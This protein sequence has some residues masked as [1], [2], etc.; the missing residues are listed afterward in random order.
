MNSSVNMFLASN[1]S[2]IV[3]WQ[4]YS[5]KIKH[6]FL[7]LIIIAKLLKTQW[8]INLNNNSD[9]I[10]ISI[11]II[12]FITSDRTIKENGRKEKGKRL[13]RWGG[14]LCFWFR[15]VKNWRWR[16]IAMIFSKFSFQKIFPQLGP[17]PYAAP[18]G[19]WGWVV[20]VAR[21]IKSN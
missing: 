10:S 16:K 15:W 9:L 18:D 21:W 13:R 2:P 17:D 5:M 7:L 4:E 8:T 6:S 19:G 1:S 12:G 3:W 14:W 11:A 20:M